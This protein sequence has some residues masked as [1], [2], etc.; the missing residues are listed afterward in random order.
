MAFT[1]V[2]G[3]E[4]Y[5]IDIL[6]GWLLAIIAVEVSDRFH[7]WRELRDVARRVIDAGSRRETSHRLR[8]VLP[9][10]AAVASRTFR[11][12]SDG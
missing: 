1:L 3:G 11:T 8:G 5:V 12:M 9:R 10:I 7:D 4:H 2:Y 6:A